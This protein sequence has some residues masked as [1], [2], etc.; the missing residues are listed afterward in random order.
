MVEELNRGRE[1]FER[2]D[3]A[4]T[5]ARLAEADADAEE[6]LPT[7]ALAMWATAAHLLGR[8]DACIRVLQRALQ[9]HIDAAEVEPAI[10]CCFWLGMTHMFTGDMAVAGG[11]WSRGWRLLEELRVESAERG[12]LLF[13]QCVHAL[14]TGQ[15]ELAAERAAEV[16]QLGRRFK[17]ADL[18][19]IGMHGRG[20]AWLSQG[21]VPEGAALMDEALVGVSAGEVSPVLAGMIYCSTIEACQ[22]VSDFDRARQWTKALTRWCDEQPDLVPYTGQCALHRGQLMRL[23]GAFP[24]AIDELRLA[25]DRYAVGGA[26]YASGLAVYERGEVHRL[27]ASTRWQRQP[28]RRPAA[29]VASPSPVSRCCGWPRA[30]PTTRSLRYTG[31]WMRPTT[32]YGVPRSCRLALRSCSRPVTS[33][34]RATPSPS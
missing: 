5:Y 9:Q 32:R 17:D 6:P 14:S 1:A 26:V 23:H 15:A 2:R 19:A 16:E 18:V 4:T 24:E 21:R 22:E 27:R 12:Y 25:T 20:R 30:A 31:C 13:P 10:R 29:T 3:W 7:S 28:T 8:T 34:L 33:R 11:W